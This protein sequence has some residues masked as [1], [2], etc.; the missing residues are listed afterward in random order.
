MPPSE[1]R[2]RLLRGAPSPSPPSGARARVPKRTTAAEPAKLAQS[3]R[4]APRG[5]VSA[6]SRPPVPLPTTCA[7][8]ATMR[9]SER[10]AMKTPPGSTIRASAVRVPAETGEIRPRTKSRARSAGTGTAES[11]ISATIAAEV[12]SQ[13]TIRR[14]GGTRSTSAESRAPENR[15][16]TNASVNVTPARN[17]DAVRW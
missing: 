10:P 14:R 4:S 8:W 3:T 6:I 16:G 11:A 17:G 9:K 13:A 1:S 7:D 5:D 12:R 2:S 15:Y